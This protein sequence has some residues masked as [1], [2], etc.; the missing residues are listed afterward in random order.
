MAW[1]LPACAE[2]NKP[3]RQSPQEHMR[4]KEGQSN[5]CS[6]IRW[7]M[8]CWLFT[9]GILCSQEKNWSTD[10]Y[11]R[12]MNPN[13]DVAGKTLAEKDHDSNKMMC[14]E[15]LSPCGKKQERGGPGL[16]EPDDP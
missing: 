15:Q 13:T 6:Q 2:R 4:I 3:H 5:A 16:R 10:S 8:D 9:Q 14:P 7:H 12:R 1:H 11:H